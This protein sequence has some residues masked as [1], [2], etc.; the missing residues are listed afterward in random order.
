M[1]GAY[2]V[3]RSHLMS[4]VFFGLFL[5]LLASVIGLG[6][7]QFVPPLWLHMLWFLDI[8]MLFV[9]MFV[10]RSKGIGMPFVLVFTFVLGMGLYPTIAAY[11]SAIGATLV[12]EAAAITGASFLVAALVA[13]RSS[14]DFTFLRGFLFIGLVAL[15]LM[16]LASLFINFGTTAALV[17]TWLGIAIF[18]GYILFDVNRMVHYGVSE[19]MVPWM[20]LSLYLDIVN[21]FLFILQLF[22][23]NTS[24]R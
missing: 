22:G 11:A 13:S 2:A 16:G 10:R 12:L 5:S 6:V 19:Q 4:R 18:I 24:R 1:Q 17:Y 14:F 3:S 23:I 7:G 9:A 15:V 20:V 21:L 8:A